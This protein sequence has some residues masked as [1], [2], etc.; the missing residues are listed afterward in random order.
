MANRNLV[1]L[2]VL[3]GVL[4]P[5]NGRSAVARDREVLAEVRFEFS[6]AADGP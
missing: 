3:T 6:V 1:D 4:T 5:I 2:G